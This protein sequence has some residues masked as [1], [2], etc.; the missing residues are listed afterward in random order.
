MPFAVPASDLEEQPGELEPR[1]MNMMQKVA[2]NWTAGKGE[3]QTSKC[4]EAVNICIRNHREYADNIEGA[5]E[6]IAVYAIEQLHLR[7]EDKKVEHMRLKNYIM[8]WGEGKSCA[9]PQC[10]SKDLYNGRVCLKHY[11]FVTV[12]KRKIS[13][14]SPPREMTVHGPEVTATVL[15]TIPMKTV[16]GIN[17]DITEFDSSSDEE[18]EDLPIHTRHAKQMHPID[19]TEL[20][21]SSDE[22][23]D[24]PPRSYDAND[25][26]QMDAIAN[27]NA[28]MSGCDA[29]SLPLVSPEKVRDTD[30]EVILN[31]EHEGSGREKVRLSLM[32]MK[33]GYDD[34]ETISFRIDSSSVGD[35]CDS[36]ASKGISEDQEE[37]DEEEG[38]DDK[39][40]LIE[41]SCYICNRGENVRRCSNSECDRLLHAA[42]VGIHG[43]DDDDECEIFCLDCG[44]HVC[45]I[46]G[47]LLCCDGCDRAYHAECLDIE[48]ADGLPN[49]WHCPDC[50]MQ[51]EGGDLDNNEEDVGDEEKGK[52]AG[53]SSTAE[54]EKVACKERGFG[55][56]EERRSAVGAHYDIHQS[57]SSEDDAVHDDQDVAEAAQIDGKE[58]VKYIGVAQKVERMSKE[59]TCH[60]TESITVPKGRLGLTL[61]IDKKLGGA[62]IT[63]IGLTCTFKESIE[64]GDRVVDIDNHKI[65]TIPDLRVNEDKTRQLRIVKKKSKMFGRN[66][67]DGSHESNEIPEFLHGG[68]RE[69]GYGCAKHCIRGGV[70]HEKGVEWKRKKPSPIPS[71][72]RNEQCDDWCDGADQ[73][74][75][76]SPAED[77]EESGTQETPLY[78]GNSGSGETDV[79]KQVELHQGNVKESEQALPKKDVEYYKLQIE[80]MEERKSKLE[81]A[82]KLRDTTE[83]KM[84][85]D[86]AEQVK[87]TA[88]LQAQV[89]QV[90]REKK[91][92]EEQRVHDAEVWDEERKR[93]EYE[94]ASLRNQLEMQS[95][96][97]SEV[98]EDE[99]TDDED[100]PAR[101]NE[102][103]RTDKVAVNVQMKLEVEE[104][105]DKLKKQEFEL[106]QAK[107]KIEELKKQQLGLNRRSRRGSNNA[108]D[109]LAQ[110]TR[111]KMSN[112]KRVTTKSKKRSKHVHV[113]DSLHSLERNGFK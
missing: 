15:S 30:T 106:E 10:T 49:I 70:Q 50:A 36:D 86:L 45:K 81:E 47:E 13:A 4:K 12:K 61:K 58:V 113:V 108:V 78:Q 75:V 43:N 53:A 60:S 57:Q 80:Q 62:T 59:S 105:M 25:G 19:L 72:K 34:D 88:D 85:S 77:D 38:D 8:K 67:Q 52:E 14:Q 22:V 24:L 71:G 98:K 6:K 39:A 21:S 54:N 26:K 1:V 41:S 17:T 64:V 33:E 31:E 110:L 9:I 97:G 104:A 94:H 111:S 23:E 55:L 51:G 92:L 91:E 3:H 79:P 66:I 99:S 27:R 100:I 82:A 29:P 32:E 18:E 69:R 44:C 112:K 42:C 37:K 68:E 102:R 95:K 48:D 84:L 7:E 76:Y 2:D 11:G 65:N 16:A 73:Q 90:T 83:S 20:N 93:M 46:G 56:H 101:L 35:N 5:A 109:S 63:E 103:R 107:A 40:P 74:A 96:W 28:K 89:D 87:I